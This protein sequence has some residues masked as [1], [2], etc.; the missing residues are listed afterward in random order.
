MNT[1][2]ELHFAREFKKAVREAHPALLLALLT[3]LHYVLELNLP[4]GPQ[5]GQEAPEAA[6]PS[7]Q[8]YGQTQAPAA[9]TGAET[10][11]SLLGRRAP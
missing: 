7:P 10:G 6:T 4:E 8:R 2:H 3:Q 11:T 1:L 5:P 9:G